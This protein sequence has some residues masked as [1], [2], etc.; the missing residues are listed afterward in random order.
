MCRPFPVGDTKAPLRESCLA[1]FHESSS[2][3]C[4]K[5]ALPWS[6]LFSGQ[7]CWCES[8]C[9]EVVWAYRRRLSTLQV[10]PHLINGNISQ[11]EDFSFSFDRRSYHRLSNLF[12]FRSFH[13]PS[14][15]CHQ[16]YLTL[17]KIQAIRFL[18]LFC[19]PQTFRNFK[20]IWVAQ[21]RP[22]WSQGYD[23]LY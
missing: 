10:R 7:S 3:R 17:Q 6:R 1:N 22:K 16:P 4:G 14:N 5:S 11:T 2:V 15:N 23:F 12:A 21:G 13:H 9:R 19:F 20:L 8:K 18:Q